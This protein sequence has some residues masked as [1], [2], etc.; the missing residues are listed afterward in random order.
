ME[1]NKSIIS[2]SHNDL[3]GVGCQV[4]LRWQ[5]TNVYFKTIS[6]NRIYDTLV[7]LESTLQYDRNKSQVIIS[8]LSLKENEIILLRDICIKN[9]E[10]K[11]IFADHHLRLPT[12]VELYKTFPKNF[13]DLYSESQCSALILFYY[14][15]INNTKIRDLIEQINSYDLWLIDKNNFMDSLLLNELYES[16]S[17]QDFFNGIGFNGNLKDD[18]VRKTTKIKQKI[19][20]FKDSIDDNS[21][22]FYND[23]VVI[24][25]IDRYKSILQY[26]LDR[27]ISIIISSNLN[28]SIRLSNSLKDYEVIEIRDLFFKFFENTQNIYYYAHKQVFGFNSSEETVINDI[29]TFLQFIEDNFH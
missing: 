22:I 12:T 26:S 13:I 16:M 3:D 9:P 2:L 24:A 15:G 10:M 19:Q 4:V 21:Y 18:I 25:H 20:S 23:M 11:F 5:F 28:F 14:Y 6:Y 8:D 7:E 29:D 1:T 17:H 27:P